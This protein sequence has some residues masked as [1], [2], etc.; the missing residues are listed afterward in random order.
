M[1]LLDDVVQVFGLAHDDV[2]AASSRSPQIQSAS[3]SNYQ[4]A[5]RLRKAVG[6]GENFEGALRVQSISSAAIAAAYARWPSTE[7]KQWLDASKELDA[8]IESLKALPDSII[9]LRRDGD[10]QAIQMWDKIHLSHLPPVRRPMLEA[11]LG[12][13]VIQAASQDGVVPG[14]L[15]EAMRLLSGSFSGS[16]TP[17]KDFLLEVDITSTTELE[18]FASLPTA[19]KYLYEDFFWLH[20]ISNRQSSAAQC[21]RRTNPYLSDLFTSSLLYLY[22]AGPGHN[23][24]ATNDGLWEVRRVAC[25]RAFVNFWFAEERSLGEWLLARNRLVIQSMGDDILPLVPCSLA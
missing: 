13:S 10:I 6:I 24:S 21:L 8:L 3:T 9:R 7:S 12:R 5:D 18:R 22:T 15:L 17:L 23:Q 19:S 11:L 25:Q 14:Q 4:T 2:N 16:K 1:V 20:Q